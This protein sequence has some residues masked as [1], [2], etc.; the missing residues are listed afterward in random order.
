MVHGTRSITFHSTAFLSNT[1]RTASTLLTVFG[2]R[3]VRDCFNC[4]TSSVVIASSLLEPSGGID[5]C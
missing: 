1:F 2:A 5:A 3:S 4:C